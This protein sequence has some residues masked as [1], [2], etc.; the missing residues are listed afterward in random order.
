MYKSSNCNR[1]RRVATLFLCVLFCQTTLAAG[2]SF[3][4]MFHV[5][6]QS[7]CLDDCVYV[8]VLDDGKTVELIAITNGLSSLSAMHRSALRLLNH[9]ALKPAIPLNQPQFVDSQSGLL[10]GCRYGY[11]DYGRAHGLRD[12]SVVKVR[13]QTR[14]TVAFRIL[15]VED[16]RAFGV[17][18]AQTVELDHT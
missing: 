9:N 18:D 5:K 15:T 13:L 12:G 1:T 14:M 8:N 2:C 17:Y 4:R 7:Q 11:I 3:E 16:Q 6:H 10:S